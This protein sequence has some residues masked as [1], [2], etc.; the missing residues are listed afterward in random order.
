MIDQE[1]NYFKKLTAP[2]YLNSVL[3]TFDSNY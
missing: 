2:V 3:S 1:N